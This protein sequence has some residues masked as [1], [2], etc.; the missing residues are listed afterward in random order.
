MAT[1]RRE[2]SERWFK[3]QRTGIRKEGGDEFKAS[4]TRGRVEEKVLLCANDWNERKV[5]LC[6]DGE[7]SKQQD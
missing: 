7:R 6:K 3:R 4:P 1:Q 2:E 5:N